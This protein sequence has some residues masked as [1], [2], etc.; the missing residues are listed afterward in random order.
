MEI[1]ITY[2]K[3]NIKYEKSESIQ[4]ATP[5][6][7]KFT[8]F[9]KN[10]YEE[11]IKANKIKANEIKNVSN[12]RNRSLIILSGPPCSGK[13]T[14]ISTFMEEKNFKDDEFVIIDPDEARLFCG[15]YFDNAINGKKH[16]DSLPT[17]KLKSEYTIVNGNM[18][19]KTIGYTKN[20]QFYGK[21]TDGKTLTIYSNPY[22]TE[23]TKGFI[24]DQLKGVI[25]T[26]NGEYNII[27]QTTCTI[28]STCTELPYTLY[29]TH[30][31]LIINVYLL[32]IFAPIEVLKER[33]TLRFKTTGRY[34][35]DNW[36]ETSMEGLYPQYKNQNKQESDLLTRY[37][38]LMEKIKRIKDNKPANAKNTIKE[39]TITWE[40][41]MYDN[42]KSPLIKNDP[43][44]FKYKYLKYKYKYLFRR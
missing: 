1:T 7:D 15:D 39:N 37:E 36:I 25:K 30:S 24:K 8:S 41:I 21:I 19:I 43:P 10:L 44:N 33:C 42:T 9:D 31:D 28:F 16:Y 4:D 22:S 18:K 26:L 20:I 23:R 3:Y 34:M 35:S 17:Q 13:S 5:I 40:I 12:P 38:F 11:Y 2:P 6:D 27:Y 32:T 14:V 29:K